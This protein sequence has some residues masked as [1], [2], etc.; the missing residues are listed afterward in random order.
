MLMTN[1][2]SHNGSCTGRTGATAPTQNLAG[3]KT[4]TLNVV[5]A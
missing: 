4:Q 2:T 1:K 5:E 3:N